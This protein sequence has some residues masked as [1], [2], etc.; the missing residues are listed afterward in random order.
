MAK[1]RQIKNNFK[2]TIHGRVRKSDSEPYIQTAL[3]VHV[4]NIRVINSINNQ[5]LT[6]H[7]IHFKSNVNGYRYIYINNDYL[8]QIPVIQKKM[9]DYFELQI[10]ER[11]KHL[12]Q[13]DKRDK[14][15]NVISSKKKRNTHYKNLES[16]GFPTTYAIYNQ[17]ENSLKIHLYEHWNIIEALTH[18]LPGG[19]Y[20]RRDDATAALVFFK[21][22]NLIS[23]DDFIYY[24]VDLGLL[25]D[26]HCVIEIKFVESADKYFYENEF[27]NLDDAI[28]YVHE[29]Q[30]TL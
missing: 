24:R 14:I 26:K 19:T 8:D 3:E 1:N 7:Y 10:Q 15:N 6:F 11:Q 22:K 17:F 23:D 12:K 21:E 28:M 20:K 25:T 16:L 27:L 4:K 18:G 29:Y 9:E 5:T 13:K 2:V 30:S